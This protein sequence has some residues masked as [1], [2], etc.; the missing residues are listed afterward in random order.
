NEDSGRP[1]NSYLVLA[2]RYD[3]FGGTRLSNHPPLTSSAG[4]ELAYQAGVCRTS[5]FG[6]CHFVWFFLAPLRISF[7]ST[8]TESVYQICSHWIWYLGLA[9]L[10]R[11]HYRSAVSF[12]VSYRNGRRLFHNQRHLVCC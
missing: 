11:T 3:P 2:L 6:L 5:G 7:R 12:K 9:N 1:S 4:C 8:W 10:V